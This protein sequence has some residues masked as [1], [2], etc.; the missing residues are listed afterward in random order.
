MKK[1]LSF[2][3]LF[4]AAI[5]LCSCGIIRKAP[6]YSFAD[7]YY[8]T[9]LG[10]YGQTK[11][12]VEN[13]EDSITAYSIE[14]GQKIFSTDTSR[15]AVRSFPQGSSK[16][17]TNAV[18]FKQVGF[19][20]DFLTIPFKVRPARA[21]IPA[22]FTT[23]LNGAVYLGYRAD[24]YQLSYKQTPTNRYEKQTTHFGFSMGFFTGL[25]GTA[26]NESVT[27]NQ[28]TYQYNGIAWS[29]GLAGIFGIN[30][31]TIGVTLGWDHLVDKNKSVWIYQ[32]RPWLG[33]AFGLNLN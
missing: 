32:G 10:G 7:G 28:V 13:S 27:D 29:K 21:G 6:K 19:D 16:S 5:L 33:L 25:G 18:N 4:I 24:K 23:D 30:N 31:F 22:Q 20:V 26:M 3:T 2:P 14:N 15:T 1:Q 9:D 17:I 12:Y 8:Y 11:V